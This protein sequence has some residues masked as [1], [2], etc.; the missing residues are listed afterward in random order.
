M[1]KESKLLIIMLIMI[2][3]IA[4][5]KSCELTLA[6]AETSWMDSPWY[7]GPKPAKK[8]PYKDRYGN[9]NPRLDKYGN[10]TWQTQRFTATC[11][12]NCQSIG[13]TSPEVLSSCIQSCLM[14]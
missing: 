12:I 7:M 3:S 11:I 14:Y 2:F 5:V 6:H 13:L 4:F 1:N 8:D 9:H 10:P